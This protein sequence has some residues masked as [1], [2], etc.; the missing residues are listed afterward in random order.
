MRDPK[1]TVLIIG[2]GINGI[3]AFRDLTLQGVD[4][5]IVD[6]TDYCSGA[7]AASSHMVHGG[8]RYLENGEFRLVREAVEERNRLIENAPHL[9][10]PL[11]TVFPI[12]KVF[13]GLLNAP[14]KFLG[15]LN[16][17]SERGAIVMK[18]GMRFYDSFTR[19]QKTVPQHVFRGRRKSRK[20]FPKLNPK[21]IYTGT[22]YDGSMQSPE[23]IAI[24]LLRDAVSS[25]ARAWAANYVRVARVENDRVYLVDQINGESFYVEPDL[26]INA[27]GPWIDF[28]NA[29]LGAPTKFIGGTKGSHLVLKHHELRH[30]IHDHEFFFE[31]KDGRIVLIFP[32]ADRVMVGT[33]DIHVDSPDDVACTEEEIDYF[34]EMVGR[35]FPDINIDR[36]HI[37]YQFSGVRPL[38]YSDANTTGQLSRDHKLDILPPGEGAGFPV[39]SLVGGK[40]TS[41]RAFSEQ[42]TDKALD[43]LGFSRTADT[44]QLSI[45]GSKNL[46]RDE[47][48]LKEYKGQ[49]ISQFG[50]SPTL[51]ERLV[52][53]YGTLAE[54]I[55]AEPAVV[56]PTGYWALDDYT[57]EEI[58]CLAKKEDVLHLDDMLLRR[59]MI[60]KLGLLS[61]DIL[62]EIAG[63][64]AQVKGWSDDYKREEIVRT[65]HIFIDNPGIDLTPKVIG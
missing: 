65:L 1:V 26:V 36:S 49:L 59:T 3:G 16:K 8:I 56:S 12:F 21:V 34:F 63:V 41:Y 45:G 7:S 57:P 33:S 18:I 37:V 47:D 40:W 6:K 42:V 35:V 38:P 20:L 48:G 4:V 62:L 31:N 11:P 23:R 10:K 64:V 43:H 39:Y 53:R 60:G 32:L 29:D 44:K 17:P 24:E 2:A 27:T 5:L 14:L 54:E 22:Y 9:V 30:A 15:L 13:S 58:A 51:V 19:K 25:S 52:E 46:P 50:A 61:Y 28:T 55:L